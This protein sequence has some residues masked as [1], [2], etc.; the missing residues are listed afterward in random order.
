MSIRN[1]VT[2]RGTSNTNDRGSAANRRARKQWL[3]D[4]FGDGTNVPCY[5]CHT[6]L[7]FET[8]TVDRILPGCLGGTYVR[9]NIRPACS[10]CNIKAGNDARETKRAITSWTAP[11]H[12]R[13]CKHC[14]M[15][16]EYRLARHAAELL[17]EGVTGAY[18]S[19]TAE[20]G[21]IITFRVWLEG[22]RGNGAQT[23]ANDE[24]WWDGAG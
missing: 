19:E 9:G 13:G 15:V 1:G 3:L 4:T 16:A 8:L 7:T 12:R 6:P 11:R 23:G 20:Y 21:P 17:R 2:V 24:E 5:D 14:A 10:P 22:L 18:R